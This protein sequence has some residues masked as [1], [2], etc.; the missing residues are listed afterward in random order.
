[1]STEPAP[2]SA[3]DALR[4]AFAELVHRV[5]NLL[6][7]I[8]VQADLARVDGSID[9]HRQALRFIADSAA[10]TRNTLRESSV[11]LEQSHAESS[12]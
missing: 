4:I 1:M 11:Q 12:E 6:G 3:D 7:T 5:N 2:G 10:K 9:V 8:Q